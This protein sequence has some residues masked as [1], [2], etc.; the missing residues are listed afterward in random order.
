MSNQSFPNNLAKGSD[1]IIQY[2]EG[3]L[4]HSFANAN[5]TAQFKLDGATIGSSLTIVP[6][7]GIQRGQG[8]NMKVGYSVE[9]IFLFR[10][11]WHRINCTWR[12]EI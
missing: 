12:R 7:M 11:W 9:R 3:I 5:N 1:T 8:A 2:D 10:L 6:V 4:N